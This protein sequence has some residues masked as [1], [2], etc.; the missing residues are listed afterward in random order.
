MHELRDTVSKLLQAYKNLGAYGLMFIKLPDHKRVTG[1]KLRA[2]KRAIKLKDITHEELDEAVDVV[3]KAIEMSARGDIKV[4]TANWFFVEYTENTRNA[5]REGTTVEDDHFRNSGK[6]MVYFDMDL[7]DNIDKDTFQLMTPEDKKS[8]IVRHDKQMSALK[9]LQPMYMSLSG[10]GL[11]IGFGADIFFKSAKFQTASQAYAEAY[12]KLAR[13]LKQ[14]TGWVFDPKCSNLSRIDRLPNT[15]NIKTADETQDTRSELLLF[16]INPSLEFTA[17]I[18]EEVSSPEILEYISKGEVH[19]SLYTIFP[20]LRD[21][22]P[23]AYKYLKEMLSFNKVFDYFD[24]KRKIKY[25]ERAADFEGFATCYSP[26][27]TQLFDTPI[28]N[29]ESLPSFRFDEKTKKFWDFGVIPNTDKQSGDAIGLA[30]GIKKYQETGEWPTEIDELESIEFALTIVGERTLDDINKSTSEFVRDEAGNIVADFRTILRVLF[31]RLTMRYHFM[32]NLVQKQFFVKEKDI[33]GAPLRMFPWEC[34][35]FGSKDMGTTARILLAEA[36][37]G[38]PSSAVLFTSRQ[39]V[40]LLIDPGSIKVTSDRKFA[41]YDFD[42]LR[43]DKFPVLDMDNPVL[44]FKDNKYYM[45]QTGEVYESWDGF[46]YEVP[47]AYD[48]VDR[49]KPDEEM[50]FERLLNSLIGPP[51]SPERLA[52]CFALGQMWKPSHGESRALVVKGNGK[53]GKSSL[54]NILTALM[55]EGTFYSCDSSVLTEQSTTA[56]AARVNLIGKHLV[57]VSDVTEH[58]LSLHLK[59]LI[60]GDDG[61]QA[62]L[63]YKNPTTFRSTATFVF[64]TNSFPKISEDVSAFLRRFILIESKVKIAKPI[65]EIDKKILSKEKEY[66]WSFLIHCLQGTR[67][68]YGFLFP[69][70]EDWA[71]DILIPMKKSMIN[72]FST[73][74]FALALTPSVGKAVDIRA[75]RKLY[76]NYLDEI[77]GKSSE[78]KTFA[79]RLASIVES[80]N[81]IY[82]ATDWRKLF[83]EMNME[84]DLVVVYRNGQAEYILNMEFIPPILGMDISKTNIALAGVSEH[85]RKRGSVGE[86]VFKSTRFPATSTVEILT[87]LEA[88]VSYMGNG[89]IVPMPQQS[90]IQAHVTKIPTSKVLEDAT[91]DDPFAI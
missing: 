70:Q 63:L 3:M 33:P 65:A 55:P 7:K 58:K 75:L 37:M 52:F 1:R 50:L 69:E 35:E 90:N 11:H 19:G 72:Q 18:R 41:Y 47:V 42:I 44:R 73:G 78:L 30:I 76:N 39:A 61:I 57:M 56:M 86:W 67:D 89:Q 88:W 45:L 27:R 85:I 14:I 77:G 82:H 12:K 26:F 64:M 43:D 9:A 22:N 60:T 49:Y 29:P 5:N 36:G 40:D 10:N 53:N 48:D 24:I 31:T 74:E 71:K 38:T 51:D 20:K 91:K 2:A 80:D 62:R 66:V 34:P 25:P 46:A 23:M 4:A 15:W 28:D 54:V 59:P 13:K 83:R 17:P 32:Y 68:L 81:E 79:T 87:R 21:R 8:W 16:D 84:E 6:H